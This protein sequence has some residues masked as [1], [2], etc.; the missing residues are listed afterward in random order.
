MDEEE[1]K[2]GLAN[3]EEDESDSEAPSEGKIIS[4]EFH[5][6]LNLDSQTYHLEHHLRSTTKMKIV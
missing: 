3:D 5:L 6:L 1:E 4:L 2:F